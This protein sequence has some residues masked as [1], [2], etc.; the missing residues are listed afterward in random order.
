MNIDWSRAP[1]GATHW[2]ADSRC[3]STDGIQYYKLSPGQ[4]YQFFN[5]SGEWVDGG[6]SKERPF[7][8]CFAIPEKDA[9]NVDTA[10][11]GE[12]L[13]PVGTVCAVLNSA[14]GS[15]TWERCTI[16]YSGKHRVMYDSESCEERVAF[17]EDLKFRPARTPEQSAAEERE[18]AVQQ[19][20]GFIRERRMTVSTPENPKQ[21]ATLA[22]E[23][24]YDAGYRKLE[25]VDG[26]A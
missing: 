8:P 25:I 22:A 17:I 9:L 19:M 26:E 21:E 3:Y 1:E 4:R 18:K 12:G 2:V 11:T 24:L 20:V 6:S 13:P 14:L 23:A 16:L 15:P 5:P 7:S 10:W